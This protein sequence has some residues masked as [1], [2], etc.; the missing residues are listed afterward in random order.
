MYYSPDRI[1]SD[2]NSLAA[3]LPCSGHQSSPVQ[4]GAL[5]SVYFVHQLV[6]ILLWLLEVALLAQLCPGPRGCSV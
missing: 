2:E 1:L 4:C 3:S 5:M 6:V